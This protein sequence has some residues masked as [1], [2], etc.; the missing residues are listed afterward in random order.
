VFVSGVAVALVLG[1]QPLIA[2]N[3]DGTP[4]FFPFG[5]SVTLP[6]ILIPHAF[7]GIGEAVLTVLVWRYAK[8]RHWVRE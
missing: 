8:A 2:H 3:A 7:I 1:I 4:L 6:A 5:L